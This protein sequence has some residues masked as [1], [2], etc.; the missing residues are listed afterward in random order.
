ML[1]IKRVQLKGFKTF[2]HETEFVFDADMTAIVGPNGCG[3]SNVADAV[4]WCM[5]EQSFG[6]LRSKRTVDVIFS[7]SDNRARMGMA[8]VSIVLDNSAGEL[9]I[10]FDEVKITRR[11]YR[12]G[13][14]EYLLNG[15]R[16]RLQDITQLLAPSGLGNRAYAVIG[17]GL[18]DRVLSLKPEE[19]RTLFEEAAGI[20][21]YQQKRAAALRRLDATQQNLER[22]HDIIAELSPQLKYLKRQAERAHERQQIEEDLKELLHTWYGYQWHRTIDGLNEA[23]HKSQVDQH[24]VQMRRD[25]LSAIR[26]SIDSMRARQTT[27]RVRVDEQSSVIISR[28]QQAEEVSRRLA[29][30]EE[31]RRQIGA[32]RDELAA[33]CEELGAEREAAL[34]RLASLR[35]EIDEAEPRYNSAHLAVERLQNRLALQ[36]REQQICEHRWRETDNALRKVDR[37]IDERRSLLEQLAGRQVDAKTMLTRLQAEI[38]VRRQ[39][40][41]RKAAS[42]SAA[43]SDTAA[44]DAQRRDIQAQIDACAASM[45]ALEVDLGNE[46]KVRRN[47][48]RE[49]AKMQDRLELLQRIRSEGTGYASGV[50]SVLRAAHT[51]ELSG[52]IGTVGSNLDVPV[53]LERAIEVALGGA[54]QNLIAHSWQDAQKAIEYL[55][56]AQAGRATFLPLDRLRSGGPIPAPQREGILGNAAELVRYDDSVAAAARQLLQRVWISDDLNAARRALDA[57]AQPVVKNDRTR[58]EHPQRPSSAQPTVVTLAGE[59]VRPGGAVT[60]GNDGGKQAGSLLAREREARELPA[61]LAN[62]RAAFRQ[63]TDK[64]QAVRERIENERRAQN[65]L[66]EQIKGMLHEAQQRQTA[67]E[68]ARLGAAQ[69]RQAAEWHA[70]LLEQS[71]HSLGELNLEE[72]T[73]R[74]ALDAAVESRQAAQEQAT[75]AEAAAAQA[76]PEELLRQL[77][78]LRALAAAAEGELKN[79]RALLEE[80]RRSHGQLESQFK[81]RSLR[82]QNLRVEAEQLHDEMKRMSSGESKFREEL[83]ELE[84]EMAPWQTQLRLLEKEQEQEETEE[85]SMQ[86]LV[87]RNE[88]AL[89]ASRLA[90]QRAEDRLDLLRREIR[91]DFGL[92]EMEETDGL[93]YQPPLPWHTLVSQLPVVQQLPSG[94]K[95]EVKE[96][97][98]RLRRLSN[99]NPEAP[100]EYEQAAERLHFLQTQSDDLERAGGDLRQIIRELDTRMEQALVSTFDAVSTEFEGFFKLL[101]RGGSAQ[102]SIT[103]P[104]D[105]LNTGIEIFARP[106]GKRPQNLDLLSGGERS[107]TACALVFAIL[108]VSPTPFCLLDEVDATLDESNVDRLRAALDSLNGQIQFI[109]ITHNRRTLVGANNIYG[110]TMGDDGASR[111][112]SLRLEGDGLTDDGDDTSEP[113]AAISL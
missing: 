68:Q 13:D 50:R 49:V 105:I 97:R 42:L 56:R 30:S 95:D 99:V 12:D 109:V 1:R 77:A 64:S 79:R 5:G 94:L 75:L 59:I 34:K 66:D 7:G 76:R 102:L 70:Q 90:L 72:E 81:S 112:I 52:I 17:Q 88:A 3:K 80:S 8:A 106:P 29:V 101:L 73:L 74:K 28:R 113:A 78:D 23:R 57:H 35:A 46:E 38:H 67:L 63:A 36:Q 65:V 60:G 16:V 111:V 54:L 22:V 93:A 18:I 82:L 32:R 2:A 11:A 48:E 89:S 43:E 9:N 83:I 71:Q 62:A 24:S 104:A 31:R 107:L 84:R 26:E 14:N 98:T 27:L 37:H 45:A 87:V 33:E 4:R 15:Q 20:T 40:A 25:R 103:D 61:E 92:A 85:R 96:T 10:A 21:G 39:D 100:K 108:R 44:S 86:Q 53:R 47:T 6:L 19:R 55:K 91:Q 41:E 110:I 69:A 51:G 58:S